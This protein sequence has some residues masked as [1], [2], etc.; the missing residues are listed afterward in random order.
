MIIEKIH[1]KLRYTLSNDNLEVGDRVY[2]IA[3]GRCIG[4][5]RWIL[6]E[7]DFK[8]SGFPEEPHIIKNLHHSDYKPYEIQTDHGFGPRETYYKIIKVEQR[9][10]EYHD[11]GPSGLKLKKHDE[12]VEI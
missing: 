8:H 1:N 12:W 6:H 7:I 4:G 9:I 10:I 2:S 5:D 3:N 11:I